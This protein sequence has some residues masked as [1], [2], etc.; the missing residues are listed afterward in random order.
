MKKALLIIVLLVVA[1][2]ALASSG[3][4]GKQTPRAQAQNL[5]LASP[6]TALTSIPT[7]SASFINSTLCNAGSPACGTGADL[8]NAGVKYAIDP[9]YPLAFFRHES[10]YGKYGIARSNR[11]LGNI[12]CSTGYIC[13]YGFRAYASWVASYEDWYGLIRYYI[14][15][16]HK[17]TLRAIINTYSPRGDDNDPDGYVSDLCSQINKWRHGKQ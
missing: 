2:M 15:S 4:T 11:S 14:D 6:D 16:W 10:S 9:A 5:T 7:I 13:Q 8:Y 1:Y 17:T 3:Q 12:R